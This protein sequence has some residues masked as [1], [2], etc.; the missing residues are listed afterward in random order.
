VGQLD[1]VLGHHGNQIAI[2]EFETQVSAHASTTISWSKW[3]TLNSCSSGANRY[4]GP[5]SLVS[6]FVHQSPYV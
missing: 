2:A 1:P 4:I 5:P 6:L 3:R